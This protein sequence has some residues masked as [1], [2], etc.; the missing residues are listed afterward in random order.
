MTTAIAEYSP[1]EAKLAELRQQYATTVWVVDTPDRMKLARAARA[2]I[3]KWRTD[4]E[5][6]RK[7]IKQPALDRCREIDSEAKRITEELLKLETP[8]DESI[9]AEESRKEAE[10]QAK[11][12]AENARIEK[13]RA[14]IEAIREPARRLI[15]ASSVEIAAE[16]TDLN[17]ED[18]A[19]TD[20]FDAAA[21]A[22]KVE[23]LDALHCLV[24]KALAQEAEQARLAAERAELA[25]L[26]AEQEDRERIEKQKAAE[27][28]K[29]RAAA[30]FAAKAKIEA[31]ERAARERI[32][33][34]ENAA[35]VAREKADSEALALRTKADQESRAA[36]EKEEARI[37]V[38]REALRKEQA[39]KE[40]VAREAQRATDERLD[41]HAMLSAFRERYARLPGF[42]KIRKAIDEYFSAQERAAA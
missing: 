31:E 14:E 13:A 37:A 26:R 28:A 8:V 40:E 11:A 35:K 9:R 22:A 19:R 36:R 5:S 10:R 6:E 17:N 33:K 2:E 1:T 30:E 12:Q 41:A 24:G 27:D 42:E 18:V 25:K 29:A 4:L 3:R 16:W 39:A 32:A 7:R 15:G 34:E 23:T 20:E 21:K 38:E